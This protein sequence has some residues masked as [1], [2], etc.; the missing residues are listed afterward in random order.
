MADY[1]TVPRGVSNTGNAVVYEGGLGALHYL[2]QT[3]ALNARIAAKKAADAQRAQQAAAKDFASRVQLS[4]KGGL[5]YLPQLQSKAQDTYAQMLALAEDRTL[6]LQQKAVKQQ[7]LRDQYNR[8][9][10]ASAQADKYV[11]DLAQKIAADKRYDRDKTWNLLHSTQYKDGQLVAPLEYDPRSADQALGT[12]R[13]HL[14]GV[15]VMKT[16]VRGEHP[17][18]ITYNVEALP[19]GR[20]TRRTATSDFYELTPDGK[21]LRD[22]KTNE[23]VVKASPEALARF[24]RD[25]V[26]RQYLDSYEADHQKEVAAAVAKMTNYQELT[27]AERTAVEREQLPQGRRLDLFK[28]LL[29]EQAYGRESTALT[30][31]AA[32]RPSAA[33]SGASK[34]VVSSNNEVLPGAVLGA[35][36]ANGAQGIV[37]YG[38]MPALTYGKPGQEAKKYIGKGVKHQEVVT[39]RTD[40]S[41]AEVSLS[42]QAAADVEY[43]Q[44]HILLRSGKTGNV[45]FPPADALR[46]AQQGDFGPSEAF[47][48]DFRQRHPEYKPTWYVEAAPVGKTGNQMGGEDDYFQQLKSEEEVFR[49]AYASGGMTELDKKLAA[50]GLSPNG[51]KPPRFRSDIELKDLAH[52]KY[53][54]VNALNYVRYS[55]S[56]KLLIDQASNYALRQPK[57]K[58]A[59]DKALAEADRRTRPVAAPAAAAP[60]AGRGPLAG[61]LPKPAA[62]KATPAKAPAAPAPPAVVPNKYGFKF[63]KK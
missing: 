21:I 41:P 43:G 31:K 8:T 50:A 32:P 36:G 13:D 23:P 20:G 9:A 56:D 2:Q 3:D 44:R 40:G 27:P 34:N 39:A 22:A 4:D 33:S 60:F 47:A 10:E 48:R 26:N 5:T 1:N 14:N 35:Q 29:T 62:A 15:E 6:S 18:Q 46:A 57:N 58:Q 55:G 37:S 51:N 16:F 45:A 19:G 61:Q 42:N 11:G 25:P 24:E 28:N 63:K 59:M 52:K 53:T 30:N 54:A 17:D 38:T 7:L 49:K 12:G